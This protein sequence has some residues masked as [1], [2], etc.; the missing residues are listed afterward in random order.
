MENKTNG[1]GLVSSFAKTALQG[2]SVHQELNSSTQPN[3]GLK[4]PG[5]KCCH[6]GNKF[7]DGKQQSEGNKVLLSVL[8]H[9]HQ[10]QTLVALIA[11]PWECLRLS[12]IKEK[13]RNLILLPL[14]KVNGAAWCEA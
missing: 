11:S 6:E 13:H 1:Q 7:S 14:L 9:L 3:E 8:Q 5:R 4:S 12:F 10:Q 2:N